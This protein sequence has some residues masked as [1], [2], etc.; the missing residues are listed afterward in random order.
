MEFSFRVKGPKMFTSSLV[1]AMGS[2]SWR[3]RSDGKGKRGRKGTFQELQ[4]ECNL[5]ISL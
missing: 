4:V 2:K 3:L 1:A 5:K